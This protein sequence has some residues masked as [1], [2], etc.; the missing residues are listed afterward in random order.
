[1]VDQGQIAPSVFLVDPDLDLASARQLGQK[2]P[3]LMEDAQDLDF[4]APVSRSR[5]H[6]VEQVIGMNG[7]GAKFTFPPEPLRAGFALCA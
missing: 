1:V 7:G 2:I 6:A 4:L 5:V 3:P